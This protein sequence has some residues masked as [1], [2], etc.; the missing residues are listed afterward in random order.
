MATRSMLIDRFWGGQR[1]GYGALGDGESRQVEGFFIN[2]GSLKSMEGRSLVFD[3]SN[4]AIPKDIVDPTVVSMEP[5][6]ISGQPVNDDEATER[7]CFLVAKVD[8]DLESAIFIDTTPV[9]EN[10]AVMK[11][12]YAGLSSG[13]RFMTACGNRFYIPNANAVYPATW[14]RGRAIWWD[15]TYYDLGT[16][17]SDGTDIVVG[18]GTEWLDHG[19][20]K[21]GGMFIFKGADG[22]W[23][24]DNQRRVVKVIDNTHIKVAG[25]V[26]AQA[27]A[28]Y[29][30]SNVHFMGLHPADQ[31]SAAVQGGGAFT[32]DFNYAVT[33]C[34]TDS[35][36][37]SNPVFVTGITAL[38]HE[39]VL[40]SDLPELYPDFQ[41]DVMRVYRTTDGGGIYFLRTEI[42]KDADA[43]TFPATWL[44]NDHTDAALN[45]SVSVP[46]YNQTAPAHLVWL[47][48]WNGRLYGY[49]DN[50]YLRCSSISNTHA[51]PELDFDK[52]DPTSIDSG[53]GTFVKMGATLADTIMGVVYEGGSYG[54]TGK[55]GGNLLVITRCGVVRW[56]GWGWSDWSRSPA[57]ATDCIDRRSV[58][59]HEGA[60]YWCT[61]RGPVKH[62]SG[63]NSVIPIYERMFPSGFKANLAQSSLYTWAASAMWNGYYVCA[64]GRTDCSD[65]VALYHVDGDYWLN[66]PYS[67]FYRSFCV[68]SGPT[69]QGQLYA[70]Q[71]GATYTGHSSYADNIFC[72]FSS[73]AAIW[74]PEIAKGIPAAF[75]TGDIFGLLPSSEHSKLKRI[76]GLS[77]LW[78][79]ASTVQ[80]FRV[81]IYRDKGGTNVWDSGALEIPASAANAVDRIVFVPNIFIEGR[82]LEIEVQALNAAGLRTT[83]DGWDKQVRL[84]WILVEYEVMDYV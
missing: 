63:T 10:P 70:T 11:P 66:L 23:G 17:T 38:N 28:Q 48:E 84:L 50:D 78:Q 29:I 59:S 41:A 73:S 25:P 37:E 58:Q 30:I 54:L 13:H 27:N 72:M 40:L 75:K 76:N 2:D 32:G 55:S 65:L 51:W 6:F 49:C 1:R 16:Y 46:L 12:I 7:K 9:G 22:N 39:G 57:F 81:R 42:P 62:I 8:T 35:G 15:G 80:K 83:Y 20:V 26:P 61:S 36:D 19:S 4:F 5:F 43:W 21:P 3:G 56:Y 71:A 68:M 67:Q 64:V 79:A 18:H 45:K 44:D 53:L 24:L 34:N 60:A 74:S 77:I 31:F 47:G 82:E 69:M 33:V 52:S 14:A